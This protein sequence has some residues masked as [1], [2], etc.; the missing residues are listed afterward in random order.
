M[1]AN[2]GIAAVKC[3]RS[4]RRWAYEMFRN[5]RAIRFVVMVTPEDLKGRLSLEESGY[6]CQQLLLMFLFFFCFQKPTQSISKWPTI[7]FPFLVEPTTTTMQTSSLFWIL[8]SVCRYPITNVERY[9]LP[10]DIVIR[11]YWP[12]LDIFP[13]SSC[14]GRMGTC[15]RKSET[16]RAFDQKQHIFHRPTRKSHVGSRWQNCFEHCGSNGRH[17]DTFVVRIW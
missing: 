7:T 12:L 16:A 4:I 14:M 1:I 17:P 8:P 15:V 11:W 9:H 3:M 2:N 5:E 13:G 6:C 10:K